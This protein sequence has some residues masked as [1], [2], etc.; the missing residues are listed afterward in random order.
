MTS[1]EVAGGTRIQVE[2][3]RPGPRP[4]LAAISWLCVP[5]AGVVAAVLSGRAA[6]LDDWAV[7]AGLLAVPVIAG[8]G[9]AVAEWSRSLAVLQCVRRVLTEVD[10]AAW[11]A[12]A[13]W[14][15]AHEIPAET[16]APDFDG[17]DTTLD[18]RPLDLGPGEWLALEEW[19]GLAD[20]RPARVAP[21]DLRRARRVVER[22]TA[23]RRDAIPE[24]FAEW[25]PT[26]TTWPS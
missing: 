17:L 2:H 24:G 10:R 19:D 6:T 26:P 7:V 12:R 13:V 4:W 18:L 23:D 5:A 9:L 8:I 3:I 21:H 22:A 1:E 15:E 20:A 14:V 11:R 16:W 25:R